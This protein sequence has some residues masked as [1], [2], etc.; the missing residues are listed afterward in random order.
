VTVAIVSARNAVVIPYLAAK[1]E[2]LRM[3][4]VIVLLNSRQKRHRFDETFKTVPIVVGIATGWEDAM[5]LLQSPAMTSRLP[6]SRA[7]M[8]STL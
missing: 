6:A 7:S 4:G 2:Q 8:E 5:A 1:A 3:R